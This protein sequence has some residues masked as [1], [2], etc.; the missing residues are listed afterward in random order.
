MIGVLGSHCGSYKDIVGQRKGRGGDRT[1]EELP[2]VNRG[3]GPFLQSH[4][5]TTL[6]RNKI[7]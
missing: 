6:R 2:R 3:N 1:P 4:S 7:M 5:Q